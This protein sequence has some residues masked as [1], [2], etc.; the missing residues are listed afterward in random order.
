MLR[1]QWWQLDQSP[2]LC[3]RS[4][5]ERRAP[6]NAAFSQRFNGVVLFLAMDCE[7]SPEN[8]ELAARQGVR[9]FP[10]FEV[11]F[12]GRVVEQVPP[13]RGSLTHS[14]HAYNGHNVQGVVEHV[15]PARQCGPPQTTTHTLLLDNTVRE[16]A[17]QFSASQWKI[18]YAVA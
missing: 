8:R 4:E 15:P 17:L 14:T 1:P 12:Q 13:A 16:G 10:T 18:K 9:A 6:C 2:F 11:Y 7:A 3:M 5:A